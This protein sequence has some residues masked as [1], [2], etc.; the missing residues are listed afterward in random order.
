LATNGVT[1]PSGPQSYG[2]VPAGGAAVSQTFTFTA[3]GV[4]GGAV[5]PT[6]RLQDGSADRGTVVASFTMGQPATVFTQNFDSVTAPALPA[7]PQRA[8]RTLTSARF[9]T[10]RSTKKSARA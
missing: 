3:S 9:R 7:A 4:C 2:V 5:V 6:L 10:D 1:S 8:R